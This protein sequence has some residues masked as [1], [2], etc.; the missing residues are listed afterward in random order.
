MR[1]YSFFCGMRHDDYFVF[2]EKIG[3]LVLKIGLNFLHKSTIK[4][5]IVVFVVLL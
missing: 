3:V 4:Y 2:V 5:C 1:A